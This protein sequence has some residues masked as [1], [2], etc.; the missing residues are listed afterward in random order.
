MKSWSEKATITKP[1]FTLRNQKPIS[2]PWLEHTVDT[3]LFGLL[4]DLLNGFRMKNSNKHDCRSYPKTRYLDR[5]L[6]YARTPPLKP[7][8]WGHGHHSRCV[9]PQPVSG[10]SRVVDT[11]AYLQL[12]V[13]SVERGGYA[14]PEGQR[15]RNGHNNNQPR[16]PSALHNNIIENLLF[17]IIAFGE[18]GVG[19]V[20]TNHVNEIEKRH[21]GARARASEDVPDT[22][23]V[24]YVRAPPYPATLA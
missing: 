8:F 6:L 18:Q 7:F 9:S 4:Q 17:F 11:F 24:P 13:V 2:N 5:D 3:H 22:R 14:Q 21:R 10:Y 23:T 16:K 15:D 1:L 20:Y 12:S 19:L